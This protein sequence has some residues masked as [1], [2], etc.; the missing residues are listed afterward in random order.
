MSRNKSLPRRN[1]RRRHSA[2]RLLRLEALETRRMLAAENIVVGD[3]DENG[4]VEFADFLV[5]STNFNTKVEPFTKG[6][7]DGNGAV[8]FADFLVLST[9]YGKRVEEISIRAPLLKVTREGLTEREAAGLAEALE[10]QKGQ[11]LSEQGMLLYADEHRFGVLP[12]NDV[13]REKSEDDGE[14]VL[15]QALDLDAIRKITVPE[16]EEAVINFQRALKGSGADPNELLFRGLDALDL[17]FVSQY[18]TFAAYGAK[19][20][21]L[22]PEMPVDTRVVAELNFADMR[23]VGPGAKLTATY[24]AEGISQVRY[25]MRGL[26]VGDSVEVMSRNDAN[27]ACADLHVRSLSGKEANLDTLAVDTELLYYAPDMQMPLVEM[28]VP[29]YRCEATVLND[30]EERVSLLEHFIVAAKDAEIT[31]QLSV[32]VETEGSRVNAK[33]NIK[34]GKAPYKIYLGASGATPLVKDTSRIATEVEWTYLG[35]EEGR[36]DDDLIVTIVDANGLQ[37]T[38]SQ[39]FNVEASVAGQVVAVA[40]GTRDYGIEIPAMEFGNVAQS[41]ANRMSADGVVRRFFWTGDSAWE[42]DFHSADDSAW[43][44]NTDIT[45]YTGHGSGGSFTFSNSAHSDGRIDT[46]DAEVSPGGDWGDFDLEWLALYSCQVLR[47]EHGGQNLLRW[48]QEFDGLHIL[49][50]FETNAAANMNF[51]GEF[52]DNMVRTPFLWWNDPMK[53]RVAWFDAADSHQPSGR[54]AVAMGPIRNDGVTNMNDYFWGKGD[55]GPD[56]RN[57]ITG[58]WVHTF[59]S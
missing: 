51:A 16:G 21:E 31:P 41:F 1:D 33:I 40:G 10:V 8:Q 58:F 13:G 49:L 45:L 25:A 55:V 42:D 5:L 47:P 15:A 6:D 17:N 18:S 28:L 3:L 24:D 57:N 43:I 37:V 4:K 44:D 26:A 14:E 34:G 48:S 53:V 20:E 36:V 46:N 9:N 35:R 59:T 29:H 23:I 52:A 12:T 50:G 30:Q 39:P 38:T 7:I 11:F 19:G 32:D 2:R 22:I 54:K 56:I 27:E